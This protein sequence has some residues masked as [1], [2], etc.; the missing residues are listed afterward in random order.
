M[1]EI[2]A[3]AYAL[4]G[5]PIGVLLVHGFTASPTELRPLGDHLH[6]RG[7]S[8]SGLRLAGHGTSI[9]DMGRSNAHDWYDS[10]VAGYDELSARCDRVVAVGLSM[11]GVLCCQLAL[12]RPLLGMS[13]LAPSFAVNS[14]LFFLAPYLGSL[15]RRW[16]KSHESIAY[17]RQHGLFSYLSMP[18]PAL[19]QLLHLIRRVRPLLTSIETPCKIFMGMRD[20]TVVPDSGFAIFRELGSRH[21]SLALLPES[22]HILTVESDAARV[23]AE[24]ERFVSGLAI[25]DMK[26]HRAQSIY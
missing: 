3:P 15:I 23:F 13:L 10:V 22:N 11:G 4:S 12:D 26:T 21:K 20:T 1:T 17:Y 9:D 7:Y 19:A 24:I 16:S 2:H 18:G 25:L 14:R 5:G 6:Q 8:I